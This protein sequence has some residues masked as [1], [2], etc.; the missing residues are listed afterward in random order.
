MNPNATH[1]LCYE[2]ELAAI[3]YNLSSSSLQCLANQVTPQSPEGDRTIWN[4]LWSSLTTIFACTWVSCHPN[5]TFHTDK[6]NDVESLTQSEEQPNSNAYKTWWKRYWA[7]YQRSTTRIKIILVALVAPE[8]IVMW[9]LRQYTAAK[10]IIKETNDNNFDYLVKTN[11]RLDDDVK[12]Q[13]KILVTASITAS[14]GFKLTNDGGIDAMLGEMTTIL[15]TAILKTVSESELL[16]VILNAKVAI[17]S[18]VKNMAEESVNIAFPIEIEKCTDDGIED[19][20]NDKLSDLL[21]TR[22]KNMLWDKLQDKLRYQLRYQ[23]LYKC[24]DELRPEPRDKLRYELRDDRQ[25][26]LWYELRDKLQDKCR[27]ECRDDFWD[28]ILDDIMNELWGELWDELLDKFRDKFRDELWDEF[29]DRLWDRLRGRLR[30]RL[31][32]RLRVKLLDRLQATLPDELRNRRKTSEND[33]LDRSKQDSLAKTFAMTQTIWFIVQCFV[34]RALHPPL[35]E[36]E[37]MAC[38]YATLNAAIYICWWHKPFRVDYPIMLPSKIPGEADTSEQTK[39]N[40]WSIKTLAEFIMGRVYNDYDF[41]QRLQVPTFYSGFLPKRS[42]D[43]WNFFAEI[44]TAAVFGGIHLFAWNYEFPTQVELW[45]WRVSA[46]IIVGIP[47]MFFLSILGFDTVDDRS[48]RSFV[49]S[50]T[51][52]FLSVIVLLYIIARLAILILAIISLRKLPVGT[53]SGVSWLNFIPHI[54]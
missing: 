16:Q 29:W 5:I 37:L 41:S 38:A 50:I 48:R 10:D 53:L 27:D 6:P 28:E 40:V 51:K 44:I 49:F 7:K 33:I 43:L 3:A 20:L 54:D 34:R 39:S 32:K 31:R 22:L 25:Y 23:L 11:A 14:S 9:A 2:S 24:Q 8:I 15:M 35:T 30:G 18:L 46:L 12:S 52:Y 26:E 21:R 13:L 4:I 42:N 47:L 36:I 17:L 19:R 1:C 45:L